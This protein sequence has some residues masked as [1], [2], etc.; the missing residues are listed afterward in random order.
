M[1][2]A[3]SESRHRSSVRSLDIGL[4]C[5]QRYRLFLDVD[6]S[7]VDLCLDAV[8]GLLDERFS[9]RC[10]FIAHPRHEGID[11]FAVA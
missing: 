9:L 7:F 5:G 11:L 1:Q 2:L 8:S 10:L 3:V 4:V 6:A